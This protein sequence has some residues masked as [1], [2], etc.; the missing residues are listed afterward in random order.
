[1]GERMNEWIDILLWADFG[2]SSVKH[3][4]AAIRGVVMHY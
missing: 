1:M 2:K 4:T 3:R